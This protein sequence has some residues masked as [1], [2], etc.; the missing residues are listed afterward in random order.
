M[1]HDTRDELNQWTSKW[2]AAQAKWAA[3]AASRPVPAPQSGSFFGLQTN[4]VPGDGIDS[5]QANHWADVY[6]ADEWYTQY[7]FDPADVR[8]D[9]NP[10]GGFAELLDSVS[11]DL[12]DVA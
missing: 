7:L 3:E 10:A 4:P 12:Q 2:E 5:R 9:L 8:T 11:C 6:A 1:H